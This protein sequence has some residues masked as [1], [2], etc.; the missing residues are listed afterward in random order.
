MAWWN[1]RNWNIEQIKVW[2]H[3][4]KTH[5]WIAS[6]LQCASQTISK[7]CQKN[8]ISCQRT[9]PRS[10]SGHPN[11]KGGMIVDKDGYILVYHPN[12]P[13]ARNPRKKY[14]LLHRL[15]MENHIKR[16]LLPL[17]V[18]HHSNKNKFDYRIENL[19]LFDKNSLHLKHELTG[20]IPRWTEDGRLRTLLGHQRWANSR[21]V[22]KLDATL[23][24]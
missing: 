13:F 7:V 12:H 9:G 20:K 14:V 8:Q 10:G 17:E 24:K 3:D 22:L 21:R 16:Y 15:V 2:I 4:G 6:Q 11:W 23:S 19:K 18:V 1:K 5:E